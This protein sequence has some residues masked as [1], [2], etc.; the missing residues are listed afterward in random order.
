MVDQDG[1]EEAFGFAQDVLQ[2]FF[3]VLLG[4]GES[5]DAYG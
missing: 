4:V 3:D 5:N 2:R 1:A